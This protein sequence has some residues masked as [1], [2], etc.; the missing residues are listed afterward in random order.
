MI[1]MAGAQS[2]GPESN[3]ATRASPS[4]NSRRILLFSDPNLAE[5]F[6]IYDL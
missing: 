5:P 6:M 4:L 3:E 1:R 2:Q